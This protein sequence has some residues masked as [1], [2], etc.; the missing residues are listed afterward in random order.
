[1]EKKSVPKNTLVSQ[2]VFTEQANDSRHAYSYDLCRQSLEISN[3]SMESWNYRIHANQLERHSRK[4]ELTAYEKTNI[5]ALKAYPDIE[6]RT[7]T[8]DITVNNTTGQPTNGLLQLIINEK[9]GKTVSEQS[10]PITLKE[11]SNQLIKEISMGKN[12]KLWNE[13]TP[14]LYEV[15]AMLTADNK[16]DS[17]I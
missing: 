6:T 8:L 13:F 2:T 10:F 15:K 12:I 4:I 14:Y 5:H 7:V 17:K 9:G 3:G 16:Q 1:M 11:G